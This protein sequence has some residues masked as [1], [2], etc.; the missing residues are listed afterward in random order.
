M[1]DIIGFEELREIAQCE[2]LPKLIRWLETNNIPYLK[3]SKEKPI[4]H[5][6]ALKGVMTKSEQITAEV[7]F[8]SSPLH[9]PG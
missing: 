2:R 1:S 8:Q 5:R 3:D 7:T 9:Q 4:V 6:E